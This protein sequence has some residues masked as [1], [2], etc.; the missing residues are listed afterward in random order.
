MLP[1]GLGTSGRKIIRYGIPDYWVRW[2]KLW[3]A[4]GWRRGTVG[5]QE[6]NLRSQGKNPGGVARQPGRLCG[7][8]RMI[9]EALHVSYAIPEAGAASRSTTTFLLR[10]CDTGSYF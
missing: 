9:C 1:T 10:H 4:M 7:R 6:S 5:S 3:V 2:G 8:S